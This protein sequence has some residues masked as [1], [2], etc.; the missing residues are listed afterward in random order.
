M[1]CS[2]ESRVRGDITMVF[3]VFNSFG[4]GT[5]YFSLLT[6]INTTAKYTE[7]VLDAIHVSLLH[8]EKCC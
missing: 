1:R 3:K 6:L 4:K 8:D 5:L 2:V 7:Y